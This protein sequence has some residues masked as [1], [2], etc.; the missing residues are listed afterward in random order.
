MGGRKTQGLQRPEHL[1]RGHSGPM[2]GLWGSASAGKWGAGQ[3]TYPQDTAP[4]Q[5]S[6]VA[7]H[8]LH[9]DSQ[10][11]GGRGA[12]GRGHRKRGM[13]ARRH[14]LTKVSGNKERLRSV[15]QG[16]SECRAVRQWGRRPPT[17]N[18]ARLTGPRDPLTRARTGFLN[19]RDHQPPGTGQRDSQRS[20][21]FLLVFTRESSR[22]SLRHGPAPGR[23]KGDRPPPR[24]S[25]PAPSTAPA[26]RAPRRPDGP[27]K[28][29][30]S[31]TWTPHSHGPQTATFQ[32][33]RITEHGKLPGD[34]R[35]SAALGAGHDAREGEGVP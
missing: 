13:R 8:R 15:L 32:S 23:W 18:A 28:H 12:G 24:D 29:M 26:F 10:G 14:I 19:V 9:V 20:S 2:T 16:G 22:R 25:A 21:A 4:I 6:K 7:P 3:G 5:S 31:S 1:T 11:W 30:T 17:G 27:A 33:H 34:Y 35:D